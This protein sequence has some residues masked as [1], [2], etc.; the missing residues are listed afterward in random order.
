MK[1]Y[2]ILRVCLP[3]AIMASVSGCVTAGGGGGGGSA[4]YEAAYDAATARIPTSDMPTSLNGN[5]K[6][7]MKVGVNSG[8]ST[9]LGPNVD[10][11]SAEV[12]GD[13]DLTIAWTDGMTGNPFTGTASSFVATEAGTA[14][15]IPLEGTLNVMASLPQTISRVTTPAQV[16]AGQSIPELNTGAFS[17]GLQGRL[18]NGDNQGDATVFLGGNFFG[19][20][21]T[22][23][24]GEV[25]G[26]IKDVG[27]PT[28][29]IFDAG[30][31]GTFYAV[32]Q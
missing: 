28:P 25:S 30:I 1:Q 9:L 8:T 16:I 4:G 11:Q 26:G 3:L 7:Q 6:G 19:P 20:G 21:A 23:M 31:G 29:A 22:A 13:V 12:I 27:N 18:A 17:V 2:Q 15:S 14:N 5:Y 32:K 10:I 24:V